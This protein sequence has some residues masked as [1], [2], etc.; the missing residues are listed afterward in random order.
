MSWTHFNK[1]CFWTST[2]FRKKIIMGGMIGTN[3][4]A[5]CSGTHITPIT[6][7]TTSSVPVQFSRAKQKE[8]IGFEKYT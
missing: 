2:F 7:S 5:H 8:R 1:Y 4:G 3:L 6:P